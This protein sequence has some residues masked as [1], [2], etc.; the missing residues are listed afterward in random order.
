MTLGHTTNLIIMGKVL[1]NLEQ[2]TI[3]P[4]G[5]GGPGETRMLAR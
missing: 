3:C 4:V 5:W 1:S 2:C